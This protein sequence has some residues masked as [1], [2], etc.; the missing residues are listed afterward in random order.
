MSYEKYIKIA[1]KN[2]LDFYV[3]DK[4]HHYLI[5]NF[6][7]TEQIGINIPNNHNPYSKRDSNNKS[8]IQLVDYDNDYYINELGLRGKIDYESDILAAGCSITFGIGIPHEGSWSQILGQKI[9]KNITNLGNPGVSVKKICEMIIK[10]ASKHKMPKTIFVLFPGFFRSMLVED[11]DF[12]T[13]TKNMYPNKQRKTWKQ[14]NFD[15]RIFFNKDKDFVSFKHISKPRYFNL[16][17]KEITYMEN[18]FSP[19]QLILDA[20]ESILVLEYFCL[21]NNI[22]LYWTTPH[23]ATSMLMDKLVKVPNFKLKKYFNFE[24]DTFKNNFDNYGNFINESCSLSHNSN[25]L[26]HPS[27]Q[28]GSDKCIDIDNNELKGWERSPGIHYHYHVAELFYKIYN[29]NIGL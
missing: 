7:D 16:K 19:H 27:W 13:S 21:S 12:Y 26:N 25:F 23:P 2:I 22:D 5:K 28:R 9:N 18:V 29:K 17:E 6:T 20:V 3:Y 8:H 10:Y 1:I 11:V 24:N 15:A 14:E 4:T